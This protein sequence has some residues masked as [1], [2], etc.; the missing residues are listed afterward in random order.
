MAPVGAA[1]AVVAAVLQ[2][3]Q[4]QQT[5]TMMV[6]PGVVTGRPVNGGWASTEPNHAAKPQEEFSYAPTSPPP[7]PAAVGIPGFGQQM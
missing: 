1:A 2:A 5:T 7:P 4:Q 6:Q 3:Q